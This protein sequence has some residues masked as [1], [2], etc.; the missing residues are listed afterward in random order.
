MA[1]TTHLYKLFRVRLAS[2]RVTTVSVRPALV[3]QA[4]PMLGG[5]AQLNAWIRSTALAYEPGPDQTLGKFIASELQ[6]AL[7]SGAVRPPKATARAAS[8]NPP[9]GRVPNLSS[10]TM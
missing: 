1:D 8:E 4:E 6:T 3:K 7:A 10:V 2:G 5:L 9:A